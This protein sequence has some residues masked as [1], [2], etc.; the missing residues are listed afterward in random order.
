MQLKI[1]KT[2]KSTLEQLHTNDLFH[3]DE[4]DYIQRSFDRLFD[5]CSDTINELL[6]I[7][8]D[9]TFEMTD[10]ERMERIDNLHLRM[11]DDYTF[12]Q[13]FCREARMLS[14]SK[15]KESNDVKWS[16]VLHGF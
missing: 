4:L 3:G 15:T 7:T 9:A 13:S 16:R 8:T 5:N 6:E 1:I 2:Y 14:L 12:C 11:L 10:Y